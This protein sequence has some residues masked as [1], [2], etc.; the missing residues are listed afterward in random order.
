MDAPSRATDDAGIEAR[1]AELER[2]SDE[3]RNE[4][5]E[6]IAEMPAAL[7]R[8]TLVRA[9]IADLRTAPDKA[10]IVRRGGAKLLRT[11]A[12]LVR[13]VSRRTP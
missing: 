3:R 5:R 2:A 10:E 8:R 13:R 9:A 6:L 7:S 1:L 4:L 12:A 11:P